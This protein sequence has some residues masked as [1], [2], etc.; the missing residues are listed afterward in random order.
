MVIHSA[1]KVL[2]TSHSL[3]KYHYII[4]WCISNST[5]PF[6]F[7]PIIKENTFFPFLPSMHIFLICSAFI[8]DFTH[9]PFKLYLKSRWIDQSFRCFKMVISFKKKSNINRNIQIIQL[10]TYYLQ[11]TYLCIIISLDK[12]SICSEF[13]LKENRQHDKHLIFKYSKSKIESAKVNTR[14]LKLN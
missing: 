1:T 6:F 7:I 5:D 13:K 4:L 12:S 2:K 10:K 14:L 11:N 9:H 3:L 8:T